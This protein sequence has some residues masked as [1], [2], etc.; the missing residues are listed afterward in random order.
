MKQ[1][2]IFATTDEPTALAVLRICEDIFEAEAYPVSAAEEPTRPGSWSVSVYAASDMAED[3]EERIAKTAKSAGFLLELETEVLPDIDWIA[4]TLRELS[5]VRAGRFVIHGSHEPDIAKTNEIGIL[6]DAGLAFGTG[7]HGTTA[8]CLDMLT[9]LSKQR[10]FGHILDLG[11][12]SGVL[13]IAA[14]KRFRKKVLAS[15]IDPVATRTARDN[16]RLNGCKSTVEC[17]VATGFRNRQFAQKRQFDLI[18][19]N[20]L[21]RPLQALALDISKHCARSGKL[22]LSGLLPHQKAA[23]IATFRTHGFRFEYVHYRDGWM[24]LVLGK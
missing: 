13:A 12:G 10:N 21:A 14:A 6:I 9:M 16:A 2:R 24:T 3:V 17:I 1:T 8:G 7:H 19:A 4:E 15:D 18:V 20:I 22:I 23:I 5:A 11:T